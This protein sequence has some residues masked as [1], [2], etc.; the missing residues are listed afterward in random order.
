MKSELDIVIPV[1]NEG[2]NIL[3]L[4]TAID[5]EVK[6]SIRVF[7]CYDFDEDNTLIALKKIQ[8]NFEVI[9]VKNKGKGVHSAVMTGFAVTNAS[10]VLTF[11]S[12]EANN[13]GIIDG[14]YAKFKEGSDVVVASRLAKGG[15]ISGGPRFK[16]FVIKIGSF[17]L[18]HFV[19]VPATDASY[20]WRLFSR[21]ILDTVEIESTAGFTYAIELLV[22]CHRLRWKVSEVPVRWIMRKTG[23]SRFNFQKWLPYYAHWFFYALATT[24]LRKGPNTVKLK[25]GVKI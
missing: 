25:P 22:K 4:F 16:S 12:D 13:V 19:G 7:I 20:A 15:E 14:M 24:Y 10:A 2:E 9:L 21:K 5:K 1:Y 6:T 23:K 17:V 11:G 18:N 3:E 8:N